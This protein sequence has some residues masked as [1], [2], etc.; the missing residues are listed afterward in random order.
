MAR[1]RELVGQKVRNMN[2]KPSPIILVESSINLENERMR[3]ASADPNSDHVR[4]F[5][6]KHVD[7]QNGET[8]GQ[9]DLE[10]LIQHASKDLD[11]LD[12]QREDEFKEYEMRKEFERRAKLNVNHRILHEYFHT[13][14]FSVLATG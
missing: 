10:R 9:G 6:P 7:H 12:R 4:N 11:E 14:R 8:F 5:L 2:G 3:L 1:L 13:E